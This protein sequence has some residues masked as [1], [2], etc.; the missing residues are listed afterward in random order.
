[1]LSF[2]PGVRNK[3]S[4]IWVLKYGMSL[5]H[6]IIHCTSVSSTNKTDCHNIYNWNIVVK[7][8]LNTITLTPVV[9]VIHL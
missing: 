2:F 8:A 5:L 3:A 4:M 7:V 6:K 9:V 1:M